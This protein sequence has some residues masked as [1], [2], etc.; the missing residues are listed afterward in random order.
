[1]SAHATLMRRLTLHTAHIARD[2]TQIQN[3][4]RR[5]VEFFASHA[6]EQCTW[7]NLQ[8]LIFSREVMDM[9][10]N[11]KFVLAGLTALT[12]AGSLTNSSA[13][14]RLVFD[15]TY[16][17][18]GVSPTG[19]AYTGRMFVTPYGTTTTSLKSRFLQATRAVAT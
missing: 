15:G 16:A 8:I 12:M 1:V 2:K 5:K 19:V 10:N 18:T 17:V 7:R 14:G 9:K 3:S 4:S 13:Q 6:S 11:M